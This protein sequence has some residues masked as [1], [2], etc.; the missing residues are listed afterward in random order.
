M[1]EEEFRA[2]YSGYDKTKIPIYKNKVPLLKSGFL[3]GPLEESWDWHKEEKTSPI[4]SQGGCG[5]CYAFATV[6]QLESIQRIEGTYQFPLSQQEL[7]DCTKKTGKQEI[8]N[9]GCDGGFMAT[10]YEYI[11]ENGLSTSNLYPYSGARNQKCHSPNQGLNKIKGIVVVDSTEEAMIRAVRQ[12]PLAVGIDSKN[13]MS[14]TGGIFTNCLENTMEH[15]V[16]IV[17]YGLD[18]K[19][20]KFWKVQNSWGNNWG[21][22]GFFRVKRDEY[23]CGMTLFPTY[24]VLE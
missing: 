5:A 12:Q 15:A 22:K 23:S 21:E 24:P 13:L 1:T 7:I 3:S 20:V 9:E 16:L 2:I 19:G 10:S 14:Y 6:S 8:E 11:R 18:E 4:Q 17:G